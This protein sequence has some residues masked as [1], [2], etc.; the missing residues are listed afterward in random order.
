MPILIKN[1][2]GEFLVNINTNVQKI[3]GITGEVQQEDY[4][5]LNGF[6]GYLQNLKK[7]EETQSLAIPSQ[8]GLKNVLNQQIINLEISY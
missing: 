8:F 7:S 3:I 2:Q 5:N 6:L 4:V 1:I